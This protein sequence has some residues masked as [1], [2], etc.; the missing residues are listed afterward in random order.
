M[1]CAPPRV[2]T[3][4]DPAK[5]SGNSCP[6]CNACRRIYLPG[7]SKW[8][9]NSCPKCNASRCEYRPPVTFQMEWKLLCQ[10]HCAPPQLSTSRKLEN[11]VEIAVPN[12]IIFTMCFCVR[13]RNLGNGVEIAVS[14][15]ITTTSLSACAPGSC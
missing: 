2:S 12:A 11:G 7:P 10:M 6:K 5:W 8:S 14:N 15:A 1:Q 9:G 4:R 13:S 3:S